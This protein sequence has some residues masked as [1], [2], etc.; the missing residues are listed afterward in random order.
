MAVVYFVSSSHSW[1]GLALNPF[2]E[3]SFLVRDPPLL[4]ML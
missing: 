1:L 2:T 3:M 4:R